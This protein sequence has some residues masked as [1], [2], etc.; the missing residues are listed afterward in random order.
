VKVERVEWRRARV[1]FRSPYVTA[2]GSTLTRE[3]VIVQLRTDAGV[4]GVGEASLLPE[5][6]LDRLDEVVEQV[7]TVAARLFGTDLDDLPGPL[8]SSDRPS[9]AEAAVACA[10]DTAVLDAVGQARGLPVARL[11]S[12]TVRLDVEVNAMI[13]GKPLDRVVE[14]AVAARQA[15]YGTVKL[16]VGIGAGIPIEARRV[17]AVREAIGPAMKLRLDANGAWG[18][19]EALRA[20][21]AFAPYGIELIEQPVAGDLSALARVCARSPIPIAAD[22]DAS[23]AE[24]VRRIVELGAAGYVVLKPMRLGGLRAALEASRISA[25]AGIKTIVTTSIDAGVGTAAALHLAATL[26]EGAPACGLAT[27]SLLES[28]LLEAP[29]SIDNGMMALPAAPGLGVRLSQVALDRYCRPVEP[30]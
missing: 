30:V 11:L 14:E 3:L 17:A 24:A 8:V 15:G 12:E 20:I 16:K 26:P 2:S 9:P 4:T 1:P 22:E 5:A 28:D 25:A 13:G 23:S 18:A 10:F 27:A 29:L 21:E 7:R 19:D 6:G